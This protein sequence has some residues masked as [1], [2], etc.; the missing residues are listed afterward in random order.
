MQFAVG[1]APN[2]YRNTIEYLW[3]FSFF[4]SSLLLV[5][6]ASPLTAHTFL[7]NMCHNHGDQMFGEN[8]KNWILPEELKL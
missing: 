4:Q 2:I 8:F 3:G 6:E 5:C 7:S 1:I